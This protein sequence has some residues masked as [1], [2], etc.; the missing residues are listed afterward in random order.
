MSVVA[1]AAPAVV[2]LPSA[3]Q[4][5]Q[6]APA[7]VQE[8]KLGVVPALM[9]FDPALLEARAGTPVRLTFSNTKCPLQHNFVLTHPG[10]LPA[11]GR[12]A[13][14]LI[15]EPAAMARHYLP[16]SPDIIAQS[17]HLIGPGQSDV[18]EFAAPAAPGD[19]PFICSFPGHWR[20]MQGILRIVP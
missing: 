6:A 4:E 9:K 1:V 15:T 17:N 18:I 11:L 16:V 3:G 2:P 12:L 20:T 10:R 8:L 7:E 5:D 13:D 14:A 19:Y